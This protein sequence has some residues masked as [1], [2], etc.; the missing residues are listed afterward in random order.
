MTTLVRKAQASDLPVLMDL[1]RRTISASYRSIL[2]DE[3]VDAFLGSGAADRYVAD[4][5]AASWVI[6]RDG[7]VLGYAVCR[8]NLIDLMLID[9][10]AHRQGLGTTLLAHVE[11]MLF[12][13]HG[14]LRLESFEANHPANAF[15]RK[16][17]WLEAGRHFDDS[18]RVC[19]L[20]F[21]KSPSPP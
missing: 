8:D 14:E 19:K 11:S 9:H 12:Q 2:G 20:V 5:I 16:H 21:R 1:S 17:G 13:T 10:T 4:N 18:S 15:Y 6:Q 3:A 7:N